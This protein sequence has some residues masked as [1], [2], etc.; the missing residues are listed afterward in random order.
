MIKFKSPKPWALALAASFA[1]TYGS[2][3]L[4]ASSFQHAASDA[5]CVAHSPISLPSVTVIGKR[6]V[7]AD[8]FAEQSAQTPP[9]AAKL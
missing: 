5:A 8:E 9:A 7:V 3:T 4:I 6:A 2:F 1:L